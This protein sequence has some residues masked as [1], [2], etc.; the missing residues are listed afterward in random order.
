MRIAISPAFF[1][2]VF[3][4]VVA[5]RLTTSLRRTHELVDSMPSS[6]RPRTAALCL[7]CMVPFLAGVASVVVILVLVGL[8][9]RCSLTRTPDDLVRDYPAVDVLA[10]CSP[11]APLQRSG[12]RSSGVLIARW[13]PFGVLPSSQSSAS[14]SSARRAPLANAVGGCAAVV[15]AL[16]RFCVDGVD[17]LDFLPGVSEVWF[18]FYA[19]LMCG[20]AA[21]G[22]LLRDPVDRRPLL[23]TGAALAVAAA[24]AF[25]LT[26]T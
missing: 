17:P 21:V 6:P 12:D 4:L 22:A 16:G 20:L 3:G 2:G 10:G 24:G 9:R 7:A 11:S 5:H 23:W 25:A 8:T 18:V 15:R 13:A 14:S 19:L 1:L 26:V